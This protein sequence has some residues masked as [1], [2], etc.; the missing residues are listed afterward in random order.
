M[1]T[2]AMEKISRTVYQFNMRVTLKRFICDMDRACSSGDAAKVL[3]LCTTELG[4]NGR[5]F[6]L[7]AL[8]DERVPYKKE[9]VRTYPLVNMRE[10]IMWVA[11]IHSA[12]RSGNLKLVEMLIKMGANV[13]VR[14]AMYNTPLHVSC[15]CG[16]VS[17]EMSRL[18]KDAA[19]EMDVHG[20]VKWILGMS[21][22]NKDDRT[23]LDVAA[24]C[25][26][27]GTEC[28]HT[29]AWL[30]EEDA[31]CTSSVEELLDD[32]ADRH[33]EMEIQDREMERRCAQDED[34]LRVE[35]PVFAYLV[36]D[37]KSGN[38]DPMVGV[39]IFERVSLIPHT[40]THTQ[41][42]KLRREREKN[43]LKIKVKD[44]VDKLKMHA[45]AIQIVFRALTAKKRTKIMLS[46][47]EREQMISETKR[48]FEHEALKMRRRKEKTHRVQ[49]LKYEALKR[50]AELEKKFVKSTLGRLDRFK[51]G[52]KRRTEER[53]Y[54][55]RNIAME[56]A[57]E[58]AREMEQRGLRQ[59]VVHMDIEG[60]INE[61]L[62]LETLPP[63]SPMVDDSSSSSRRGTR[64]SS[65]P[66][67][68][69][70]L[71]D[72]DDDGDDVYSK[73]KSRKGMNL[74]DIKSRLRDAVR[75]QVE[76][77][78]ASD[79]KLE[80]SR[81]QEM[82]NEVARLRDK[83][84]ILTQAKRSEDEKK[85]D[86]VEKAAASDGMWCYRDLDGKVFG[87]YRSS[88]MRKWMEDGYFN[89]NLEV[90]STSHH[91]WKTLSDVFD[92]DLSV[93]FLS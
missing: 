69:P 3:R 58:A 59:S 8:K 73:M 87:P 88:T 55:T 60:L 53:R 86:L 2:E 14:D 45:K 23:A 70:G 35:D 6:R 15:G 18:I 72:D 32:Q 4:Q 65:P 48:R 93:A 13:D 21:A 50:K 51:Q 77:N 64:R 46:S 42:R 31:K 30:V 33:R 7:A 67:D 90:R 57:R 16:D 78:L 10:P 75:S 26:R 25:A 82:E 66:A 20:D 52:L 44:H 19:V 79:L 92:G 36:M 74:S 5:Y 54:Q 89:G 34:K 47:I 12:V 38:R 40:Y 76:R 56:K 91:G 80:M 71:S 85:Q 24:V 39:F 28:A 1:V 41:V 17:I 84:D 62:D 37:P 27:E 63:P 49:K 68:P 11:P 29:M 9:M 81:K 83:I 61:T 22:M 43:K